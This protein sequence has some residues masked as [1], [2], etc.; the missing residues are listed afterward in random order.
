MINT[1]EFSIVKALEFVGDNSVYQKRQLF[2]LG[3]IIL[4][5]A[6]LTC[7]I[8]IM[9]GSLAVYFL[10]FSGIGQFVCPVYMS[11]RTISICLL[12]ATG[13]TAC[14]WLISKFMF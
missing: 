13:F 14:F 8:P 3:I 9:G 4:A 6:T 1:P 12:G 2:Y 11:L 10:F 5:F 7:R